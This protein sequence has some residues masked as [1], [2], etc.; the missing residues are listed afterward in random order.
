MT[1]VVLH[2]SA[3]ASEAAVTLN[4][5]LHAVVVACPGRVG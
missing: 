1:L 5:A 4:A 2:R 3:G